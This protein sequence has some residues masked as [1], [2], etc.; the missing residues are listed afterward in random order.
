MDKVTFLASRLAKAA[1]IPAQPNVTLPI[2]TSLYKVIELSN[3]RGF[4][5]QSPSGTTISQHMT[6]QEA[7]HAASEAEKQFSKG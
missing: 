4:V 3:Q 6:R 1:K 5:V 7:E 2:T